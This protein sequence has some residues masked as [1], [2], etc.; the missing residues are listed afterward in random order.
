MSGL[1]P[2]ADISGHGRHF[3]FVPRGDL[4]RSSSE[5]DARFFA[6]A[7]RTVGRLENV[8][9]HHGNSVIFLR[10]LLPRLSSALNF[11]YLDAHGREHLPLRE[12][13][14]ILRQCRNTV[15]M[16]DDFK[17]PSDERFGCDKYDDEHEICLRYIEGVI[18]ANEVY[19]P[20]YPATHEAGD[21]SRRDVAPRLLRD[22]NVGGAAQDARWHLP[23]DKTQRVAGAHGLARHVTY[24]LTV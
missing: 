2:T 4:P 19:L 15:V 17:V 16:I 13:L 5:L 18:D 14:S 22:R 11:V 3:A 6:I 20:G 1:P 24:L 9:L 8:R 7:Q 12:E 21:L 23:A 10:S